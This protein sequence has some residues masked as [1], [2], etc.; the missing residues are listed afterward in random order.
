MIL[1]GRAN[2]VK[3][4]GLWQCLEKFCAWLGQRINKL[5]TSIFFSN[6]TSEGMKS[7]IKQELRINCATR[8]INYLGLPLF[9]SQHKDTDFN[10]ILDNFV[11]KLHA[12]KLK[13][14][15]KARRANLIK[16]VRL[17]LPVYTMQTTKLSKKLAF[18]IDGMAR[19]F[20]WVVKRV[21][22]GSI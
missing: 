6:N 16:S 20:W 17:S 22:E 13:T 18:K 10:F 11:A 21:T 12:W 15:S 14:L 4:R 2:L 5:K 9:R 7:D 8:N 3:V 1:V 19:D